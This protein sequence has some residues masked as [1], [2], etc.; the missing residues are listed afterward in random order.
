M[1]MHQARC[2]PFSCLNMVWDGQMWELRESLHYHHREGVITVPRGF[3]T[4]LDSVPRL[5]GV[6][7]LLKDRSKRPAV[8]HD[9]LYYSQSGRTYADQMFLD[10]MRDAGVPAWQRYPL[11]LG[12]RAGGWKPYN[13]HGKRMA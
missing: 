8:V 6:Y 1:S 11:Y 9:W 13:E 10:A 3:R 5:P 2:W 4:D 7:W 12:V